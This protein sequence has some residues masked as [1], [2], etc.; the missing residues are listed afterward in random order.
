M[1]TAP[2][3]GAHERIDAFD[4]AVLS[5]LK[6]HHDAG[7]QAAARYVADVDRRSPRSPD[8]LALALDDEVLVT[9]TWLEDDGEK[10][11]VIPMTSV[12]ELV[13]AWDSITSIGAPHPNLPA[14]FASARVGRVLLAAIDHRGLGALVTSRAIEPATGRPFGEWMRDRAKRSHVREANERQR[15]AIQ[16]LYLRHGREEAFEVIHG[17][18]DL[19]VLTWWRER[20][21]LVWGIWDDGQQVAM[22]REPGPF[23]GALND[24]ITDALG[25]EV[26]GSTRLTAMVNHELAS[27]NGEEPVGAKDPYTGGRGSADYIGEPL[28]DPR[29]MSQWTR[30]Q[31]WGDPTGDEATARAFLRTV[32]DQAEL[33]DRQLMVAI[34]DDK[35]IPDDLIADQM[36]VTPATVRATRRDYRR[37]LTAI[38]SGERGRG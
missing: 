7:S 24:K 32:L 16:Q 27:W 11:A 5:D 1:T 38:P 10:R 9:V 18:I 4:T 17:V 13:P 3:G 19:H 2:D 22:S 31:Q 29:V 21:S 36:G 28:A 33:T 34:C 25:V 20:G 12:G 15:Q 8:D 14:W 23:K 6:S 37:K 26:Q 35:D 30:R